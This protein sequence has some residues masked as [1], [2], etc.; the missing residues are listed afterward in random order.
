M[1]RFCFDLVGCVNVACSLV[2]MV[3]LL[4]AVLVEKGHPGILLLSAVLNHRA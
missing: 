1:F 2:R 4:L 3:N